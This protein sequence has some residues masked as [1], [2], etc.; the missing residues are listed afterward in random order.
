MNTGPANWSVSHLDDTVALYIAL[1]KSILDGKNPDH[2]REG[3]YLA[4]SGNVSWDDMYDAFAGALLNSNVIDSPNDELADESAIKGIAK[5]LGCPDYHVPSEFG[6]KCTLT[7]KHG[8]SLDWKSQHEPAHILR[9]AQQE[10]D[11][12]LKFL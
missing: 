11:F 2:N 3:Y 7:T 1:L 12:V 4:A 6:G 5:V 10:V 8:E 9:T